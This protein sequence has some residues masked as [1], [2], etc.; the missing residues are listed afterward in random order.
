MAM[1]GSLDQVLNIMQGNVLSIP[2]PRLAAWN[3][4]ATAT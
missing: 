2:L 1:Q 3:L 4:P